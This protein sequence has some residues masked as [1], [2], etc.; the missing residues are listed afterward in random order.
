MATAA[1]VVL[2]AL[3][4]IITVPTPPPAANEIRMVIPGLLVSGARTPAAIKRAR[5]AAVG[6]AAAVAAVVVPDGT[7]LQTP[8]PMAAMVPLAVPLAK[9]AGW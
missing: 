6:E 9:V 4:R 1:L 7:G 5:T 3:A 8:M 2:V